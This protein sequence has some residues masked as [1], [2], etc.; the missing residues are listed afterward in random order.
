MRRPDRN[1]LAS[2]RAIS[3]RD[4]P[5]IHCEYDRN[6]SVTI[7]QSV[8]HTSQLIIQEKKINLPQDREGYGR[9]ESAS[10]DTAGFALDVNSGRHRH[11]GCRCPNSIPR[12]DSETR[13]KITNIYFKKKFEKQHFELQSVVVVVVFQMRR[14]IGR[15]GNTERIPY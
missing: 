5:A 15:S 6:V 9:T 8:D 3:S 1:E 12:P 11:S 10:R 14:R 13:E 2:E 7:G 4:T